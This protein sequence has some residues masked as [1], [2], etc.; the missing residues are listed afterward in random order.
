MQFFGEWKGYSL[1]KEKRILLPKEYRGLFQGGV[2][3]TRG[4]GRRICIYPIE[5]VNRFLPSKIRLVGVDSRGRI[6]IPPY[7]TAS[8]IWWGKA[9]WLGKGDHLEIRPQ[10]EAQVTA[11]I[12]IAA[13]RREVRKISGTEI[14]WPGMTVEQAEE[15]GFRGVEAIID[16]DKKKVL[17]NPVE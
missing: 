14:P 8:T 9:T 12:V 16:G 3:I 17:L 7:F 11:G 2:V 4:F 1:D 6:A 13:I 15:L 5:G 10:K